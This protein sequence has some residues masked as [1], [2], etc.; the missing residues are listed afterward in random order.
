MDCILMSRPLTSRRSWVLGWTYHGDYSLTTATQKV[1]LYKY[2]LMG[3]ATVWKT[4]SVTLNWEE[5]ISDGQGKSSNHQST[6]LPW[7]CNCWNT[8][9]SE[10]YITMEWHA[11]VY[12]RSFCSKS[13]HLITWRKKNPPRGMFYCQMRQS[14]S[15]LGAMRNTG[16][17]VKYGGRSI[18]ACVLRGTGAYGVK[19]RWRN[20]E[21]FCITSNHQLDGWDLDTTGQWPQRHTRA[22]CKMEQADYH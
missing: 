19:S 16:P 12:D 9:N 6:D 13:P 21:I 14:L 10:F 20:E 8:I 2:K 11:Y 7:S 4:Q 3:G 1:L 22:G 17:T 15:C 18:M 5:I